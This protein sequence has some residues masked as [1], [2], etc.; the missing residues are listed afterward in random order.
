LGIICKHHLGSLRAFGAFF[1]AELNR[2]PGANGL[3]DGCLNRRDVKENVLP[4]LDSEKTIT[5]IGIEELYCA[6]FSVSHF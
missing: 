3:R 4:A 5:F 6:F 1:D 2:L